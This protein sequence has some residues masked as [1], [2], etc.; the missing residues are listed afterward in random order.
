MTRK[1]KL[2]Q[3]PNP[4]LALGD[5]TGYGGNFL[6]VAV[7]RTN[8]AA[9]VELSIPIIKNLEANAA[10][11]YDHYNDFGSTTNPKLSLRWNPMQQVLFRGAWGTGFIA[12]SLTQLHGLQTSGVSSPG[13][14]DP[15]RCPVTGDG[16]DCDTQFGVIFGG[17]PAL[18]PEKANQWSIGTVIEPVAG[19]SVGVDYFD[20]KLK[21]LFSNGVTPLTILNNLGQFGGLVVRAAPDPSRPDLPGRI[22][23]IDQ[24]FINLGEVKV[25][26]FDVDV[27]ARFPET[28]FGRFTYT[29]NGTYYSKWD[30]QNTDGTFSGFVSNQ[31]AAVV[32]GITPRW[33]HY[34]TLTLTYGPWSG[35]VAQNYQSGYIDNAAIAFDDVTGAPTEFRRVG[36]LS[37]WDLYGSY[38]GFKNLTLT[39]G[40]KNIMDQNPPLTNQV[41]TFQAG[42]DPSYYDARG[43]FIY[44][45]V[46]YAF[47]P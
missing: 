35:T 32:T 6:P 29:L 20:I 30:A 10:V 39:L 41:N 46:T 5:I 16:N 11:R 40:V 23:T 31:Y 22:L 37:I 2:D 19:F 21:N 45:S 34:Q 42:F 26:G 33:K 44:G 47:K 27:R 18:Q 25:Q 36:A 8:T 17:N 38:S 13:L 7:D 24:R 9:F 43:R 15:V 28:S 1:E 12:P 3:T 14:T 4:A